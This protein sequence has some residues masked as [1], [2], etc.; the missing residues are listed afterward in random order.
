M[1]L[2]T[3]VLTFNEEHNLP[4]CL[5]SLRPLNCPVFVVDSGSSDATLTIAQRHG[6]LVYQHGFE[7]HTKQWLWALNQLP[8]DSEWVLA[9]DADQRLTPELAS[10]LAAET[11]PGVN[12]S[13]GGF[14]LN[15]RQIFRGQWI[16]HGGYYPKYLL[17]LFRPRSVVF[18]T[19]DLVDHHF[20]VTGHTRKLRH[21]L[22]ES[23][24]KENDISFWVEK[25]NRHSTLLASEEMLRATSTQQIIRPA[26]TGNPDQR[27][28]FSKRMWRKYPLLLRSL[29][30][31]TYR[32]FILGGWLDGK[33]GF[34]FH[35]LQGLWFRILI[36]IKV[37]DLRR[38]QSVAKTKKFLR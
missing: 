17:K 36:D 16:K 11:A 32:Y 28:L 38:E 27:T 18:D 22:I 12:E 6:A 31:F 5:E 7:T 19:L 4:A 15:R 20:Y 35:F 9:L 2:S 30:Y 24:A 8:L 25:H 14:F 13:I 10:E 33:Q 23:N 37:S 3:V 34:V 29:A 21:D 1:Q 26:L